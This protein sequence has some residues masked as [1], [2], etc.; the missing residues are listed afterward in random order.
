MRA[1]FGSSKSA[2]KLLDVPEHTALE[3][4]NAEKSVTHKS[5]MRA[6]AKL[7][8]IGAP[9]I[10][11][12]SVEMRLMPP[13]ER[14]R[15]PKTDNLYAP[16]MVEQRMRTRDSLPERKRMTYEALQRSGLMIK[17]VRERSGV[18]KETVR[19]A[20]QGKRVG[21]QSA[22][23]LATVLGEGLSWWTTRLGKRA[24]TPPRNPSEK[25]L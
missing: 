10:F 5:G 2:M 16:E 21:A 19:N 12:Q 3:H 13:S 22:C 18:G 1:Y 9:E 25:A 15:G 24:K 11:I 6:L 8:Q 23:P 14:L 17:E 20:L 7:R 4:L